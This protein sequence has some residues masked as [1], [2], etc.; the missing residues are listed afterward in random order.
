MRTWPLL[1][2]LVGCRPPADT[3]DTPEPDP[4][5]PPKAEPA[6]AEAPF[7]AKTVSDEPLSEAECTQF[8]E[9]RAADPQ[10]PRT[11][12]AYAAECNETTK[13]DPPW[14]RRT[15]RCL[16]IAETDEHR[17]ACHSENLTEQREASEARL[18]EQIEAERQRAR[19]EMLEEAKRI[20][21]E[22]PPDD[23]EPPPDT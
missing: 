23:E 6:P 8:G 20:L 21:E 14:L 12:E 19:D 10:E 3:T 15:T 18:E 4:V 2:L 1:L 22:Q 17:R 9:L 5:P 13:T 11:A 16:L 7:D